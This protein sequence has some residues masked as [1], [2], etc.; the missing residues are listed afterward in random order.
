[1]FHVEISFTVIFLVSLIYSAP[2][3]ENTNIDV[4]GPEQVHIAY[5][6]TPDKMI[7]VWSTA[8]TSANSTSFVTYGLNA[9]KLDM[10]VKASDAILTEGNPTGLNEI[11]RAVM[12]V[13]GYQCLSG[14]ILKYIYSN[15]HT[16][17]KLARGVEES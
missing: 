3:P 9:G 6:E 5:D 7:V 14:K 1:M 12:T 4:R 16:E 15:K 13:R 2:W 10:V 17:D 11:H 8:N